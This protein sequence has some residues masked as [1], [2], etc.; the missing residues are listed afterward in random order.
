[1]TQPNS[2]SYLKLS[3][4]GRD[5]S[6]KTCTMA[7]L[8]VGIAKEYANSDP[9]HVF[10][11]SDRWPA[12]KVHIFDVEKVPLV[13]TAGDSLAA[14]LESMN[15]FLS[16][17]SAVYV[18]DDLTV[19]WTEGLATFAYDN[20]N[21]P[22]DRRQQLMN[23]W[24][25]FVRPFQLGE[26]HAIACGRLGYFWENV[27]DEHGEIK[28][29]QG[30]S[31]FNAGGGQNFGYD[32]ILECEM[33][34]RKRRI[35][36]L[37]RGK[38]V[39]EYVCDVVKDANSIINNQQFT[40]ADFEKGVYRP[41][42]YKKVLDCFRPHIEF[43]RKLAQARRAVAKSS[44]SLIV[45]GRTAWAEDQAAR[46]G[47]LEELDNLLNHCFPGGEKRSKLDAMYRNLALEY[48][49]GF[50][51]W[52]RM[53]EEVA[54]IRLKQNVEIVKALRTRLGKGEKITDQPSVAALLHL[55]T[56]DVLHPGHALT[57]EQVLSAKK[58]DQVK[59]RGPQPV[60]P[61]LD[62]WPEREVGA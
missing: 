3:T 12:W 2:G 45:A 28:L 11:S 26:F 22:F 24:N 35:A 61:M 50:S 32:C 9:V 14:L 38:T 13:I 56:E 23:E 41:G 36:G 37:L 62:N 55:A 60:V 8:A 34:R 19:P 47:Y 6:G 43:R 17:E 31:K 53:Q 57:L 58:L 21:L 40:F 54:T 20:G 4:D 15:G 18:A 44:D 51:S 5:G 1:M 29:L 33:R 52:S 10:D 39:M 59:P 7:Q 27:E 49:N 48:L 46:K 42:D 25:K 16:T 30:D